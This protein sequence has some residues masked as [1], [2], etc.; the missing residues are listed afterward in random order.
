MNLNRQQRRLLVVGLCVIIIVV[1]LQSQKKPE[2]AAPEPVASATPTPA[3]VVESVTALYARKNIEKGT[4]FDSPSKIDEFVE[5]KKNIPKDQLPVGR[6]ASA[7]RE[8][9]NRIAMEDIAR[10]EPIVLTRFAFAD[11]LGKLSDHIPENKR[12][13]TLRIDK[14]RGVAGF[15][16][17]GDYV[18]IIGSFT[19]DGR[20]LTKYVLPRVKILAVNTTFQAGSQS[21]D[22]PDPNASPAPGGSPQPPP[23]QGAPP[24]PPSPGGP[25][26]ERGK[27]TGQD[28]TLI[29]FEVSPAEAERLIVASEHARLYLVLR[30]PADPGNP[31]VDPVDAVDVYVERPK[32]PPVPKY[33]VVIW[34]AANRTNTPVRLESKEQAESTTDRKIYYETKEQTIREIQEEDFRSTIR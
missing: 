32:K 31:K 7:L 12:A 18:D 10:G 17:Q 34:R 16:Q 20:N 9:R 14:V 27:I 6:V 15:V 33:D 13:I 11:E 21:S 23:P 25:P 1:F 2:Q 22:Q 30:N 24:T 26:G 3:A 19:V 29:T 4:R 5:Q 8:M 28:V